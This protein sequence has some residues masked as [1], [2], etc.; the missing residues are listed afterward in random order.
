VLLR[1]VRAGDQ[2]PVFLVDR[3]LGRAQEQRGVG[4]ARGGRARLARPRGGARRR[5]RGGARRGLRLLLVGLLRLVGLVGLVGLLRLVPG[6][7]PAGLGAGGG[8]RALALLG[9]R[10]RLG[11]GLLPGG[12]GGRRLLARGLGLLARLLL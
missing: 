4:L 3:V 2:P 8:A 6:R 1:A 7:L 12:L 11:G 9:G 10:R 5:P